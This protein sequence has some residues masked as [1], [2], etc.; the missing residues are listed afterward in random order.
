MAKARES[1]TL[2]GYEHP[3]ETKVCRNS[4]YSAYSTYSEAGSDPYVSLGPSPDLYLKVDENNVTKEYVSKENKEVKE[5]PSERKCP[6]CQKKAL[7]RCSCPI[8]E[9][10]CG[11][12]HFWATTL[13]GETM[14]GDPHK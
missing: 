11:S 1:L 7:Y 3:E 9:Y 6:T 12:G 4:Q 2:S 13:S 5:R 10:M 8:E 14:I